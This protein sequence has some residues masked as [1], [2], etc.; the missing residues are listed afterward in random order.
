[1]DRLIM[2]KDMDW[3][4]ATIWMVESIKE[5]GYRANGMDQ[6]SSLNLQG[7]SLL[8]HSNVGKNME[9]EATWV[10]AAG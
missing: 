6:V 9:K 4:H 10:R 7:R 1:L 5:S 3:A 8:E 2:L